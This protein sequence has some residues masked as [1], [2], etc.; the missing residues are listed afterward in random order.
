VNDSVLKSMNNPSD[1]RK[2]YSITKQ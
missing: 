2:T 1:H